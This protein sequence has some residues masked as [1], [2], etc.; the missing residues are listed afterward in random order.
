MSAFP[1]G[2]TDQH[3]PLHVIDKTKQ[4]NESIEWKRTCNDNVWEINGQLYK[5][6]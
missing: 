4:Q 1:L 6:I 2:L 3:N 5:R